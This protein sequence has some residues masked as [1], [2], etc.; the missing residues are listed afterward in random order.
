MTVA[1]MIILRNELGFLAQMTDGPYPL[2]FP[3]EEIWFFIL[4]YVSKEIHVATMIRKRNVSTM[5]KLLIV[6]PSIFLGI[7]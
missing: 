5:T 3:R 4:H 2:V 7:K 6:L 1:A